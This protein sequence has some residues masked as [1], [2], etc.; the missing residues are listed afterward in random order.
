MPLA[1]VRT[2]WINGNLVFYDKNG[3]EIFTIDGVNRKVSF[4][5]AAGLDA[6]VAIEATD[7]ATGAVTATKLG[8]GAAIAQKIGLEVINKTGSDIVT[9]KLVAVSGLDVTSGKPKIVLADADVAAHEDVWVTT[10]TIANNAAGVVVK[11]ALSAANLNTNAVGTAGDPVYLDVTAG[12][13]TVTAP[14]GATARVHPVGMVVVKSATVGQI[15]WLCSRVRKLGTNE[16]QALA[17]TTAL[18]A[19][20]VI[21]ADA[22]GRALFAAGIF[23]VATVDS[24]FATGSIGEDR[25]TANEINARVAANHA[26]SD[27]TA[28][29]MVIHHILADQAGGVDKDVV[30]THKIR[31]LDVIVVNAAAGGANDT[32]TVKNGATAITDAID[33]NKGDKAVTRAGTI[34]AAQATIA[35]AGTLRVT[36]ADGTNDANCN[37]FVI[38][39]RVV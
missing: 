14:T 38:A 17:I 34:D 20:G 32:I 36:K 16:L 13:F 22:A 23:D 28:G 15:F 39:M 18:L 3:D 4:N 6:P 19:A 2:E 9:D 30:V 35:A 8:A 10:A 11:A 7:I 25:L 26:A 37:V 27:T 21:S 1:L 24:A 5:S 33:T 29:L 31:V 12:G